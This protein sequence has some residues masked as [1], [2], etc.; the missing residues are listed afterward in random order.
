MQYG[1][2]MKMR[3]L[4][5]VLSGCGFLLVLGALG[6]CDMTGS[7]S[8]GMGGSAVADAERVAA[9]FFEAAKA[10]D[11]DAAAQLFIDTASGAGAADQLKLNQ[12]KLG[13]LQ[14]YELRDTTVNTIFSGRRFTLKY[15]TRYPGFNATETL[16]LFE[17]VSA[18]GIGIEV[19]HVSSAGLRG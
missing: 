19:Y 1:G 17:S 2:W 6:G 16:I 5:L 18:P 3:H 4:W 15:V 9:R 12:M 7:G 14:S 8:V 10:K 13:D 11:Y